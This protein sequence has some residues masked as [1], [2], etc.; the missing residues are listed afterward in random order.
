MAENTN[1]DLKILASVALDMAKSLSTVQQQMKTLQTQLQGY[2]VKL[3]AGLNRAASRARINSDIKSL[4]PSNI[5]VAGQLDTATTRKQVKE[6]LGR[7]KA[8]QVKIQG[9]LDRVATNKTL[10]EQI[11]QLP[12][13][14][15]TANV[16]TEGA[17]QVENLRKQMD[18]AST[19]AVGMAEK[20][21]LARTALQLLRRTAKD[22][23]E[24]V[25]E[26]DAAATNL[27]IITGGQ[28]G[29]TYRML[30][31]YN[32]LAREL[33][34]TTIQISD[35][36]ASWLR[37]GKDAAETAELIEQSIMLSKVAM[38]DSET[39]TKNLTSA[40]K[41]YKLAVEDAGSVVDNWPHWT[42]KRL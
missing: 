24:T 41:G 26:L 37:Q 6:G 25:K 36:A 1:D 9:V 34:A 14:E 7:L 32:D 28:S 20:L 13:V 18:A 33:G 17:E 30:E 10:R 12:K 40:M 3:T 21:Y 2:T 35:A 19:S 8:Q 38:I 22:A 11:Q 23:V 5:K 4:K 42:A 29:E 31:E 27:A 39:A 16:K 15:A